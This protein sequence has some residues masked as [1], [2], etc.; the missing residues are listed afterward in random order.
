MEKIITILVDD[1][2]RNNLLLKKLLEAHAPQLT[3]AATCTRAG[4]ALE[5]IRQLRPQLV[6]LDIEMPGMNGF[7]LLAQLEP[8]EFEVVF[9]TAYSQ[10]AVEAFEHNAIGYLTKPVNTTRL[11]STAAAA[12]E[13]IRRQQVNSHVFSMLEHTMNS[14][15]GHKIPLTTLNGMVFVKLEEIIYCESSGNYTQFYLAEN[16]AILV[17]RQL[18]EYEKLLPPGGFMRIHDQHIINLQYIK[19]YHKGSGG[20]VVLENGVTLAVAAR[21]KDEFLALFEKWL[22]RGK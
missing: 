9:V 1:E 16:R 17:S 4:E 8:L 6:F 3:V 12:A 10:Y 7:E 19:E 15:R 14:N 11:V 5:L 20:D 13:R 22:K 21:R 2:E 18:G